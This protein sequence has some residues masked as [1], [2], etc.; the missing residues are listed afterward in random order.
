MVRECHVSDRY[1][2]TAVRQIEIHTHSVHSHMTGFHSTSQLVLPFVDPILILVIW[3]E[4]L[5]LPIQSYPIPP[6][7]HLFCPIFC[8]RSRARVSPAL[9]LNWLDWVTARRLVKGLTHLTGGD[10]WFCPMVM[11]AKSL[12]MDVIRSPSESQVLCS[13][14]AVQCT[15]VAFGSSIL[16]S[17]PSRFVIQFNGQQWLQIGCHHRHL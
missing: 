12:Y 11:L 6:F 5:S 10:W 8:S 17:A 4:C 1:D 7:C 16:P 13:K 14:S 9:N 2:T 15:I 3:V